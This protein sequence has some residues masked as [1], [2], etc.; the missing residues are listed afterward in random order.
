MV[1]LHICAFTLKALASPLGSAGQAV[2]LTVVASG[3]P[4][5]GAPGRP[6]ANRQQLSALQARGN[7]YNMSPHMIFLYT[8]SMPNWDEVGISGLSILQVKQLEKRK[9]Y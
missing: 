5:G 1:Q 6:G 4:E 2:S 7:V 3:T 9:R 8:K